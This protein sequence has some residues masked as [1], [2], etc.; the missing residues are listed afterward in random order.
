[1]APVCPPAGGRR[2]DNE[3]EKHPKTC[4]F[5]PHLRENRYVFCAVLRASPAGKALRRP[6][7]PAGGASLR[8]RETTAPGLARAGPTT[9]PRM[10]FIHN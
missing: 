3:K 8:E 7:L 4:P 9:A 10:F 6:A 1:M 5:S 2:P